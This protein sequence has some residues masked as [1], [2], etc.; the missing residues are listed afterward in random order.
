MVDQYKG[1]N[2]FH[3][4]TDGQEPSLGINWR[5]IKDIKIDLLELPSGKNLIDEIE[6]ENSSS[7]Y[8]L[9][10]LFFRVTLKGNSFMYHQI[11]R[12]NGLLL[13]ILLTQP[14]V[15]PV[16]EIKEYLRP[17]KRIIWTAPGE[18]LLLEHV[19]T[20]ST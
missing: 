14:N 10:A 20:L 5:K 12:M 7:D 16:Q 8:P 2:N 6:I 18:T 15:D 4:F 11:R 1:N 13:Q 9:K 3:N 19:A 17:L